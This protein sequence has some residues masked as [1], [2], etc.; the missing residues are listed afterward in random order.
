MC[1]P[2]DSCPS[3]PPT[4]RASGSQPCDDLY[5]WRLPHVTHHLAPIFPAGLDFRRIARPFAS[6]Q[7]DT[8]CWHSVW[9]HPRALWRGRK[10]LMRYLVAMGALSASCL[11]LAAGSGA[12]QPDNALVQ[13]KHASR[14]QHP[15]VGTRVDSRIAVV[16]PEDDHGRIVEDMRAFLAHTA[17]LLDAT[18][19]Q[20]W[21]KVATLAAGAQPPLHLIQRIANG[22]IPDP[23]PLDG[24]GRTPKTDISERNHT[25]P[26]RMQMLLGLAMLP[27]RQRRLFYCRCG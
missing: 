18:A 23:V 24:S 4:R 8:C 13:A 25:R 20:D 3:Q 1:C 9:G 2:V 11:A 16:L 7:T 6:R 10:S 21:E 22:V 19:D 5:A 27:S 12:N 17:D 26:A 14:L 15:N